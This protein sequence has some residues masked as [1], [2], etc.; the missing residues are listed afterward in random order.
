MILFGQGTK[1]LKGIVEMARDHSTADWS[2]TKTNKKGMQLE[3]G[4]SSS[5]NQL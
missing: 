4:F 2:N 1:T 3:A 5:P